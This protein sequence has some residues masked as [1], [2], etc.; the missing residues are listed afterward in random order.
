MVW[1]LGTVHHGHL[2]PRQ[3]KMEAPRNQPRVHRA[4]SDKTNLRSL[5]VALLVEIC[6]AAHSNSH[7]A[8]QLALQKE[9]H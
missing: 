3:L 4:S 6:I 1:V 7:Q 8:P 5:S 9:V 2:G